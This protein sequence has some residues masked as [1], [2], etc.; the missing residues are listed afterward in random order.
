MSILV[1]DCS[2]ALV[3]TPRPRVSVLGARLHADDGQ[4]RL[5][6]GSGMPAAPVAAI[7]RPMA[8][9]TERGLE[10]A[11]QQIRQDGRVATGV[12]YVT[13][14]KHFSTRSGPPTCRP[15]A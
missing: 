2:A 8:G 14:S 10:T 5:L 15:P 6:T 4:P 9:A 1:D 3:A 13:A 12:A 11:A 7:W